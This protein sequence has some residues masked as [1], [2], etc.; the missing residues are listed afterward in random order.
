MERLDMSEIHHIV[1][2]F[3]YYHVKHK[4]DWRE[5]YPDTWRIL[6]FKEGKNYAIQ[7]YSNLVIGALEAGLKLGNDWGVAIVPSRQRD[8]WGDGLKTIANNLHTQHGVGLYSEALRR[9]QSIEK[10]SEG[11][12]RSVERH[13]GTIAL[14]ASNLPLKMIL[15]DDVTSTGNSLKACQ[16]ILE[17]AGVTTV[18]PIAIGETT[19]ES[20]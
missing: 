1:Q 13:L 8:R 16:Q 3:P 20:P 4:Q 2:Y 14:N 12:D 19:Y 10:L 18:Y 17:N 9:H 5:R 15:L 7:H 6:D 11:G